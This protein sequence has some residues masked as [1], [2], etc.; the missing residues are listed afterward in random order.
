MNEGMNNSVSYYAPKGM[1]FSG[2]TSLK[3]RVYVAAGIQLVG[4]RYFWSSA[5]S[6]LEVEIPAQ[7]ELALILRD[8]INVCK[9]FRE[10]GHENMAKQIMTNLGKN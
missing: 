10:R 8:K 7:L 9:F 3:T 1:N 2:T 4:H 6:S 5:L